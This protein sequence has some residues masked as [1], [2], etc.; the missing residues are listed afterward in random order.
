M[1]YDENNGTEK[2]RKV[3][4]FWKSSG[5]EKLERNLINDRQELNASDFIEPGDVEDVWDTRNKLRH[6]MEDLV[7]EH[8]LMSVAT[9]CGLLIREASDYFSDDGL[10]D[11]YTVLKTL[12]DDLNDLDRLK[13][14]IGKKFSAG[15]R[16]I[17]IDTFNIMG[18]LGILI[19]APAAFITNCVWLWRCNN[20]A[21]SDSSGLFCNTDGLVWGSMGL[22]PFLMSA[23]FLLCV[24]AAACSYRVIRGACGASHSAAMIVHVLLQLFAATLAWSGVSTAWI[25]H[26]SRD[27]PHFHSSHSIMGSVLLSVYAAQIITSFYV[28]LFGSKELRASFHVLHMAMGQAVTLGGLLVAAMG[29]MYFESETYSNNW[30]DSGRNGYW[31]PMMTATQY[32]IICLMFSMVLLFYGKVLKKK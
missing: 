9:K 24:P 21:D 20:A 17:T 19:F 3:D 23:A 5:F 1:D 27:I 31:R 28:F 6:Q 18:G 2:A 15:K 8:G 26:D 4:G 16:Q 7:R 14:E 25:A 10:I 13:G 11:R 22:H 32:C 29:I 30:D 12:D